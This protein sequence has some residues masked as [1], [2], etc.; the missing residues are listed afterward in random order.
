LN[1][2]SMKGT[3]VSRCIQFTEYID[4]ELKNRGFEKPANDIKK[5]YFRTL[6]LPENAVEEKYI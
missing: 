4:F 2:Q 1:S 6:G 5:R 3:M